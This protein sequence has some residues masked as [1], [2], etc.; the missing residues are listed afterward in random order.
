MIGGKR[1]TNAIIVQQHPRKEFRNLKEFESLTD[2]AGYT[3]VAAVN[4]SRKLDSRFSVGRDKLEEIVELVKE[5]KVRKLIFDNKLKSV[6][7]YNIA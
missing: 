6:Q 3:I 1:I 4:Q 7:V 5:H 2:A